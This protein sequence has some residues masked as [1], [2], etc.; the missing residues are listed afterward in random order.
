MDKIIL[1]NLRLEEIKTALLDGFKEQFE[2]RQTPE[3]ENKLFTEKEVSVLLR[4]SK[5]TLHKYRK[6]NE[7]KYLMVGSKIRYRKEDLIEF[8]EK[9]HKSTK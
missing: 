1:T 2:S 5:V 6:L 4:I 3:N 9:N 8:M 7:L